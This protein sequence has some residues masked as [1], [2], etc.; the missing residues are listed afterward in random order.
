MPVLYYVHDP[1]CSWCWGFRKVW[2]ELQ[3]QLNDRLRIKYVLGGLAPD[4][5]LPMPL[6]MQETISNTWHKIQQE[7]PG[8]EFNYNFWSECQPRRSTYPACRAIIACRMQKPELELD[9]LLAIQQAYYLR[10][11]NP[12]DNDILR[13]LASDIGLDVEVFAKDIESEACEK[14]LFDELQESR[15]LYVH[16]FPGLVLSCK[17]VDSA[18][19]IDYN[20]SHP[21]FQSIVNKI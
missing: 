11:K 19:A 4:S 2:Q 7:I 18:I 3:E 14:L 5:D 16:S 20:N 10:A 13:Q 21:I 6:A 9:M 17:D 12:S 15:R 1:M 8:T